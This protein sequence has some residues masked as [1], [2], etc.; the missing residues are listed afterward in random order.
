M[1]DFSA[2]ADRVL[3]EFSAYVAERQ[4]WNLTPNNFEGMHV[5]T[6]GGW[7]LMRKSLH[8]PQIPINIESDVD[9]GV[10]SLT[11]EVK[12]FLTAFDGLE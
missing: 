2:Y 8:D 6:D 5:T 7:I 10:E 9:G 11:A 4:G 1:E 3:A 12:A